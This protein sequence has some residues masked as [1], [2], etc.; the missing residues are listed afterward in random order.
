MRALI[1]LKKGNGARWNVEVG[2]EAAVHDS[3]LA[4]EES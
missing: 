1:A 4:D 2:A 3:G